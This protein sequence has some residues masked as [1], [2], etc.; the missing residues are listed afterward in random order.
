MILLCEGKLEIEIE[1]RDRGDVRVIVI[2]ALSLFCVYIIIFGINRNCI[3]S[4]IV[5]AYIG[6][7]FVFLGLI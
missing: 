6:S 2:C 4:D 1:V 5:L 7:F 3:Y